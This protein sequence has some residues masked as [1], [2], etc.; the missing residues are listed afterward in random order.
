MASSQQRNIGQF[1][2]GQDPRRNSRYPDWASRGTSAPTFAVFG[3]RLDFLQLSGASQDL[4]GFFGPSTLV[5]NRFVGSRPH[6][7]RSSLPRR[8]PLRRPR[9]WIVFAQERRRICWSN[10]CRASGRL[11][12]LLPVVSSSCHRSDWS[13]IARPRYSLPNHRRFGRSFW[14][15]CRRIWCCFWLWWV[16]LV[17]FGGG[18][19]LAWW[20]W[21][22]LREVAWPLGAPRIVRICCSIPCAS[23]PTR[24]S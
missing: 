3:I 5:V 7:P 2:F 12:A 13:C 8:N 10:R 9:F 16:R 24:W 20:F 19:Y 17:G 23:G 22:S 1:H 14:C 15:C 18:W 11:A 6:H 21:S 4:W